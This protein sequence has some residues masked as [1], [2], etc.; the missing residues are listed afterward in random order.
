MH[1]KQSQA[2]AHSSWMIPPVDPIFIP[3]ESRDEN[4]SMTIGI[5][6]SIQS[7]TFCQS[8][9]YPLNEP[10]LLTSRVFVKAVAI[11]SLSLN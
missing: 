6:I 7:A 2:K 4:M 3:L 10:I 1:A 9:N 8:R 5:Q 11:L